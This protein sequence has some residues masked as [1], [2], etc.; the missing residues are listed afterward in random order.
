MSIT[1]LIVEDDPEMR[2][3]LK[4][5]A[6]ESDEVRVV[7]E[8]ADGI[9]TLEL[10]RTL[11]P[12]VVFIDIDLPE[13]DGLTLAREIFN[14]NPWTQLVFITAFDEYREAAF[15]VYAGDYL[16]KPFKIERL[17][18]TMARLRSLLGDQ[19]TG[20]TWPGQIDPTMP[21]ASPETLC[22]FR[23][24]SKAVALRLKD[25]IFI[26]REGRRT[27][28]YHVNGRLKTNEPL[29]ALAE[30]VGG[31]PFL[32]THKGF[33]VNLQLIREIIPAGRNTFELVMNYT[34]KRPL[35]TRKKHRELER[36]LKGKNIAE[37][38]M[39]RPV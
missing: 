18:Q 19:S 28:I 13:K 8:A 38:K 6:E 11:R 36:A 4:K 24:G 3:V 33:I 29:N 9:K 1:V 2:R 5:V 34:E 7:G 17:R 20:Q 39:Q 37:P 35:L 25:V 26:T 27:V 30:E 21:T 32:R 23:A 16:V 31:Y 15:G 12:D 22:L 14:H 10:F